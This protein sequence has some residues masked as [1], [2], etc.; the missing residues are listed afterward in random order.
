MA[1]LK[2]Y[3]VKMLVDGKSLQEYEGD[4]EIEN[5]NP[6]TVIKYV[7]ATSNARF[8]ID[9]S[10]HNISGRMADAVSFCSFL[11]G[12]FVSNRILEKNKSGRDLWESVS[13]IEGSRGVSAKGDFELRPFI[14]SA[15]KIGQFIKKSESE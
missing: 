12:T 3:T 4:G 10:V 8:I 5:E 7:E 15:I 6:N 2:N 11:D 1:I 14:F 13:K 9:V